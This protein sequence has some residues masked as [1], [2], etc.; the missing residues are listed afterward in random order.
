MDH[1]RLLKS[2]LEDITRTREKQQHELEM[3]TLDVELKKMELE[4]KKL[5][6]AQCN[7]CKKAMHASVLK[8]G[9]LIP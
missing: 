9:R 4:I 6:V 5:D 2:A 1:N 7:E 8:D 3:R